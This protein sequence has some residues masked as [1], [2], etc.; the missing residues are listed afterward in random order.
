MENERSNLRR[1]TLNNRG[2]DP[3]VWFKPPANATRP[4]SH[5]KR[6]PSIEPVD[7]H[8]KVKLAYP[9]TQDSAHGI[10]YTTLSHCWGNPTTSS[11]PL[12]TTLTNEVS[13]QEEVP[14]H[15]LPKNFQHA[16]LITQQLHIR[17][18]WIDSLCI[19]QDSKANWEEESANM[20]AIY[21]G[22]TPF[23]TR[24]GFTGAGFSTKDCPLRNRSASLACREGPESEDGS[25]THPGQVTLAGLACCDFEDFLQTHQLWRAWIHWWFRRELTYNSDQTASL[26][27]LIRFYQERT[28]NEPLLG[29]WKKHFPGIF[30]GQ[31][32]GLSATD[33]GGVLFPLRFF[34]WDQYEK[35]YE[36]KEATSHWQGRP[37]TSQLLASKLA[38]YAKFNPLV[39]VKTNKGNWLVDVDSQLKIRDTN[40]ELPCD[41]WDAIYLDHE[42]PK[43]HEEK[44]ILVHLVQREVDLI[45]YKDIDDYVLVLVADQI[46]P[47]VCHKVGAGF[48]KSRR[49]APDRSDL[50]TKDEIRPGFCVDNWPKRRRNCSACSSLGFCS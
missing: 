34:A 25:A 44:I 37:F 16:R 48:I 19:I 24:L 14:W 5:P 47:L 26:A 18:I 10:K 2:M 41:E 36:I 21:R 43:E 15:H 8:V 45:I 11:P 9:E 42:I 7:D 39:L 28:H 32:S 3:E 12:R 30:S 4:S 27:S 40:D 50:D 1:K 33:S 23:E 46:D 22:P 29:L 13:R 35:T 49:R 17:Y 6:L 31:L 38:L 20:A